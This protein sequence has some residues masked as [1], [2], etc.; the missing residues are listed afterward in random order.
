M[1]SFIAFFSAVGI[2]WLIWTGAQKLFFTRRQ[3]LEKCIVVVPVRQDAPALE[4][5]ISGL[6]NV[7]VYG[8]QIHKILIADCGL[9]EEALMLARKLAQEHE[10][11]TLCS[12]D[13]AQ[14]ETE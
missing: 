6:V 13:R 1:E 11:V 14:K 12:M 4:G 10:R 8:Q 7:S 9:T 5:T 3:P 2:A